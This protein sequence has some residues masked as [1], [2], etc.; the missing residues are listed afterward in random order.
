MDKRDGILFI[1]G[2]GL[3]TVGWGVGMIPDVPQQ[4]GYAA[5]ALGFLL[6]CV[7]GVRFVRY[8][9]IHPKWQELKARGDAKKRYLLP[10]KRNIDR[11]IG[12]YKGLAREAITLPLAEY[13]ERYYRTGLEPNGEAYGKMILARMI[14]RWFLVTVFLRTCFVVNNPYYKTLKRRE[15][16]AGL[17][18]EYD[19]LYTHVTD[20]RLKGY[21]TRL[22]KCEHDA[23]SVEIFYEIAHINFADT[24]QR[25]NLIYQQQ[26]NARRQYKEV[27]GE[28]HARIDDLLNGVP[29]ER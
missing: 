27:L 25:V 19:E 21:L 17:R 7:A 3:E 4:V 26:E 20:K 12:E 8:R 6:V 23:T 28:V 5:V 18:D 16:V 29:D 14:G 2:A 9:P 24:P 1:I 15:P 22:W 13:D 11:T 10:L